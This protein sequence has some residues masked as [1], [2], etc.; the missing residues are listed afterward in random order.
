MYLLSEEEAASEVAPISYL[1]L[2]FC[3]ISSCFCRM[4]CH[5]KIGPPLKWSPRINIIGPPRTKIFRKIWSP[6]FERRKFEMD[7]CDKKKVSLKLMSEKR[8]GFDICIQIKQMY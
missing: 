4:S 1:N 5:T 6:T 3:W 8:E 7:Q 2:P